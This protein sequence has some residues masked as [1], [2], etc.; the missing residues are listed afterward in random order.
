MS[1]SAIHP[2]MDRL[3][4]RLLEG[5]LQPTERRQLTDILQDDAASRLLY[6][7][8]LIV[9]ALL[10]WEN[11]PPILKTQ[12]TSESAPCPAPSVPPII[13]QAPGSSSLFSFPSFVG[14]ILFSYLVAALVMGAGLLVTSVWKPSDNA[15]IAR[16]SLAPDAND[17]R[18]PAELPIVGRITGMVDCRWVGSGF[19]VQGDE[20]VRSTEYGVRSSTRDRVVAATKPEDPSPKT[21]DLSPKS[22]GL[23]PSSLIPH[24]S[25]PVS[26]GDRFALASGLL[27]ITY[28][29]GARVILQGPVTYEV[30]SRDGGYLSVG[31]L[32]AKVDKGSGF[33]VQGDEPVRGT[34]YE[35]RSSKEESALTGARSQDPRP[36]TQGPSHLPSTLGSPL[37][38]IKTPTATVTDLGTEFGVEVTR[39]GRTAAHVFR[40]SIR[41]QAISLGGQL[42]GA[43]RV[44]REREAA[45]V[46]SLGANRVVVVGPSIQPG[47][48]VRAIP[49]RTVKTLDLV[50]VV[51]GGDGFSGK[52]GRGIDPSSGRI[53]DGLWWLPGDP[54]RSPGQ[55]HRVSGMPLVDGVLIP[56][57]GKS[58]VQ[59]D[60]AGH[61]FDGFS[62]TTD[63]TWQPIWAGGPIPR[64]ASAPQDA[65][66]PTT[67][68]GG[69]DYASAGHGL[70]FLHA[71]SAVTFDLQA[72]RRANPGFQ[73]QR[74]STI[75]G[76]VGPDGPED[77]LADIRVLVDG[78]APFQRREINRTSGPFR[79]LVTIGETDRFLTLA[80]T[81]AADGITYDWILF[82]DPRIELA[83]I[84]SQGQS[85]ANSH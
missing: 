3:L 49:Q 18:P 32:T 79:A 62:G 41:L 7:K 63:A 44:L 68:I 71:N 16:R 31:K 40:G 21:Q 17:V 38:T 43:A 77:T 65:A 4:A 82:G 22:D 39:E 36:K 51:A 84:E 10:R 54:L 24:L 26:L 33:R 27:E 35:V 28:D 34:E 67:T 76:K 75:A 1:G 74:F 60:S 5:E 37:F 25:S 73:P 85:N 20:P 50:D 8:Y 52:R 12:Q 78:R 81:S 72:I 48:F 53:A 55:Y 56:D 61:T 30:E 59:V 9:D 66:W 83:P 15:S 46:D 69:V 80:A 58:A 23:H 2:D 64:P 13:I 70:I 47:Q 14:G 6:R 29:S 45:Q 19:R 57:G 11:A 42:E